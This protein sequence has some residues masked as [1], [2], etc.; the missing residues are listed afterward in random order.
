MERI[1][2]KYFLKILLIIILFYSEQCVPANKQNLTF[3][4][5]LSK[6]LCDIKLSENNIDFGDI[7]I[8][9][10]EQN[11]VE[12]KNLNILISNCT[13]D[14]NS[15]DAAPKITVSGSTIS[16]SKSIFNSKYTSTVGFIFKNKGSSSIIEN[17][18][19]VW[20]YDKNNNSLSIDLDL[21]L[22]C[23]DDNCQSVKEGKIYSNVKFSFFYF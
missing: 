20:H 18:A 3:Y 2:K 15:D 4:V 9:D 12:A 16:N 10:I 17:N 1:N 23:L 13:A 14:L 19:D 6:G 22:K 21:S 8:N 5:S 7:P 11:N